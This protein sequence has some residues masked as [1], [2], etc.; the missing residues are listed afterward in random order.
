MDGFQSLRCLWKY[1][2]KMLQY[3]MSKF[4]K[5]QHLTKKR[6]FKVFENHF[7]QLQT[8]F[9]AIQR[10]NLTMAILYFFVH[11]GPM[12]LHKKFQVI[13][14]KNEGLKAIFSISEFFFNLRGCFFGKCKITK[15]TIMPS[16]FIEMTLHLM[17]RI[18][19]PQ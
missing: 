18:V 6:P 13:L 4:L 11:Y 16:Y 2:D 12:I 19:G 14:T 15:T 10:Q 5:S 8:Q 1:L 7:C 17:C 9:C 3:I